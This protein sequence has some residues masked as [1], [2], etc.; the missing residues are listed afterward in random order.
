MTYSKLAFLSNRDLNATM[1]KLQI[2]WE[3]FMLDKHVENVVRPAVYD[4]WIRCE[5]NNVN[6]LQTQTPTSL[7]NYDLL[8]SVNDSHLF[9]VAKPVIERLYNQIKNTGHLITLSNANGQIIHLQGDTKIRSE[10]EN[11]NFVV[12]SN[13]S[14]KSAGSNAIGT[15]LFT[16]KSIQVF[17]YE[18]FCKGVHPWVC[19]AT[20]IKNPITNEI[21][22]V[23]DLTGPNDVAQ[24]HSL[25]LVQS[26]SH[27]IE[28]NLISYF[29][30]FLK[31]SL[32]EVD[33]VYKKHPNMHYI[34]LDEK[35]EPLHFNKN[36]L[37]HL[38]LKK[39]NHL[40]R[41]KELGKVRS[42]LI[43]N[44]ASEW[45][46]SISSIESKL[47]VRK[48]SY[49]NKH[50]GYILFFEKD[51]SFNV[52]KEDNIEFF[53]DIIGNS[54][55]LTKIMNKIK[56]IS[57]TTVPVLLQ[58][59]SGTGKELFSHA[60]HRSS[61]RKNKPYI[62]INCGAIP[63]S[64]IQSELFGYEPGSFTG[65]DPKGKIGKFEKA[66]GGTILLDEIGE[67]PLDLQV[68]LLRV[69]QEKEI[70]RLGSSKPI[71]IDVR[72]IAATNKDLIT[73]VSSNKFRADLYFRLNVVELVLPPLRNRIEDINLLCDFFS[74][75]FSKIYDKKKVPLDTSV[76]EIFK[77]YSWP[78]NIRELMNV[79]EYSILFNQNDSIKSNS[80]P[81]TL[82]DNM[83]ISNNNYIQDLSSLEIEERKKLSYLLDKY[84]RNLS[85]VARQCNIARSTLYRKIK[86]YD[87]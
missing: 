79:M 7:N 21:V 54:K 34:I 56:L 81:K 57:A 24:A 59:E 87:L 68:H 44:N 11:M 39:I 52:K 58:G 70:V 71:P 26:T 80:L 86:K 10:A 5:K 76:L 20:P 32:K 66:N 85:E 6:P 77:S 47:V 19:S 1:K 35:L 8:N 27:I 3:D 29:Q 36:I 74:E 50:S 15:A 13:W 28:Q 12:G 31:F 42:T 33:K 46:W 37:E 41:I 72:I 60:I 61:L 45:E 16:E 73:L 51:Y 83:K 43:N 14:E 55:S 40:W 49:K 2:N 69:L 30:D 84:N 38:K 64:L 82:L 62:A 23:I 53:E 78:G 18:H 67:M 48:V 4:S 75:K 22:G 9:K 65:G 63:H 17:S 25:S